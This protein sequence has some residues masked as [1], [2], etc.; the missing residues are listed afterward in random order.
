MGPVAVVENATAILDA[1]WAEK[2]G[3]GLAFVECGEGAQLK[4]S[5]LRTDAVLARSPCIEVR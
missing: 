4:L 2:N 3:E 5:R 1:V